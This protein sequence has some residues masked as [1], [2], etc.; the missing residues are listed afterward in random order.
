MQFKNT[1]ELFE[2]FPD[3]VLL[4]GNGK[5]ENKG[6]LIDSYECVIRFND[7]IIEGYEQDV[8]TKISAIS[9]HNAMMTQ[10]HSRS[11][12]TNYEKYREVVPI[13]TTF[14]GHRGK[15]DILYT[16]EH[17]A[18]ISF[19]PPVRASPRKN[20]SSGSSLALTLSLLFH[21]EV[22]LIGFD[23]W[24]TGHYYEN[25]DVDEAKT[26]SIKMHMSM[27]EEKIL[28]KISTIKIL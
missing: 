6:D 12:K 15:S 7:F 9:F 13:F 26:H 27:S 5:I 17:T 2:S 24:K 3:T 14:Q 4:V 10:P 25:T 19:E 1:Q 28:K 21:R 8:G 16:E 22:H 20:L 11:L 18:L 23:F